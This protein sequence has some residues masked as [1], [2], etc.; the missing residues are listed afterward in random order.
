MM[1]W[2]VTWTTLALVSV[3]GRELYMQVSR[4]LDII[5]TGK[6]GQLAQIALGSASTTHWPISAGRCTCNSLLSSDRAWVAVRP[7]ACTPAGS[8]SSLPQCH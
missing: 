6:L 4:E 3:Q 7:M 8:K 5:K 1:V 2:Q